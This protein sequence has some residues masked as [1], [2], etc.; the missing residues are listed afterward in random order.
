MLNYHR[1]VNRVFFFIIAF[2]FVLEAM[3][4]INTHPS[5]GT[6]SL[7]ALLLMPFSLILGYLISYVLAEAMHLTFKIIVDWFT[8]KPNFRI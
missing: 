3:I 6:I 1:I 4:I 2:L 8:G 5:V 7:C